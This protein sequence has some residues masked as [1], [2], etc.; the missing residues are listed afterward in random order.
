MLL[1]AQRATAGIRHYAAPANAALRLRPH[2]R[3]RTVVARSI[4][5][6][7]HYTCR[8]CLARFAAGDN[9]KGACRWDP[10]PAPAT[11][12]SSHRSRSTT[13]AG[14]PAAAG[15]TKKPDCCRCC[16]APPRPLLR[17]RGRQGQIPG[18]ISWG[19][20]TAATAL[21]ALA[22]PALAPAARQPAAES[23]PAAAAGHRIRAR[24]RRARGPAGGC[25]GQEG[26]A[27]VG[28]AA[29]ASAQCIPGPVHASPARADR[30]GLPAAAPTSPT[31]L[32][33]APG[34]SPGDLQLLL[35]A[36]AGA[37]QVLGLLWR[38]GGERSRL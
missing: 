13:A 7:Q 36:A 15:L 25:G 31:A 18:R 28:G 1:R 21:P 6:E 12:S 32:D 14:L 23:V 5:A 17:R 3:A 24:Q 30:P 26:A 29:A 11:C 4:A 33:N 38:R 9:R 37:L 16:Q 27:E 2:A 35:T 34:P 19:E 20:A 22:L 10:L 8:R